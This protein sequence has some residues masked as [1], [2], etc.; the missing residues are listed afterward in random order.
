MAT[1]GLV[2]ST[3]T[4]T[5]PRAGRIRCRTDCGVTVAEID[6]QDTDDQLHQSREEWPARRDVKAADVGHGQAHDDRGDKALRR[7]GRM[8]HAAAALHHR[9]QLARGA[10]HLP[11]P[12]RP[13]QE[14][15]DGGARDAARHADPDPEE[16]L[17]RADSQPPGGCSVVTAPNTTAPRMPPTGSI[18]DPSQVST[19]WSRSAGRMALSSGP[20]T[21]GP[22]TTRMAPVRSGGASDMPARSP[23]KTAATAQVM[24]TPTT[25][26]RVTIRRVCPRSLRRSRSRA[27]VVEDDCHRQRNQ[28][29]ERRARA[30][31]PG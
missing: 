10:E 25:M 18:S 31:V 19:R 13:Q 5:K 4:A 27:G 16:E 30:A 14:P 7:R 17:A 26:S 1:R 24:G 28:R 12:E 23:A 20:T 21:V 8:S 9:G 2:T 11:E 29:L 3:S 6:E 22:E 15:Q